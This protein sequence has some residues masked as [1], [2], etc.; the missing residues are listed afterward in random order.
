M[1]PMEKKSKLI[2]LYMYIKFGNKCWP[3]GQYD[4]S[5]NDRQFILRK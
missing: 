4:V 2:A 3:G 5:K 1:N